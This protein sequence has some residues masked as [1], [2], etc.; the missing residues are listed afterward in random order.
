[1]FKIIIAGGRD[2]NDY[3]LLKKEASRFLNTLDI[4]SGLEIVSGGAK[5]VDAMGERFAQENDFAVKLFPA[6]WSKYGRSAGPKRN[7]QM[8]EYATHLIAFWN[9][10]SKGTKSMI[11]LAKKNDLN[12]TV[13]SV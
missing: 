4:D 10:E 8:A 7:K 12:V 1:M 3:D 6:D 13:I 11:T 5:G 9:G 2:F